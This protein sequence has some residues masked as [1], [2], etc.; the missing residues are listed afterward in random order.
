LGDETILIASRFS[1]AVDLLSELAA[2]DRGAKLARAHGDGL[3]AAVRGALEAVE[4]VYGA[5]TKAVRNWP[6]HGRVVRAQIASMRVALDASGAGPE[7]RRMAG[8]LVET[9]ERSGG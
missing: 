3:A 2:G 7:V 5:G 6:E 9:I 1:E 4:E 8:A